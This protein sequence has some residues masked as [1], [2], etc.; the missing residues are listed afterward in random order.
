LK[1]DASSGKPIF[2][3][4]LTAMVTPFNAD[5]SLDKAGVAKLASYLVE[6]GNDGLVLNGTTGESSTVQDDEKTEVV[7][8]V[9]EA[10]GG[11]ACVV[12]GVGSNDTAHSVHLAKE[13]HAAGAD[14]LM[15]VTP[16]YNKPQQAG[17]IAHI[18]EIANATPL[19]VMTYDIPGR[20]GI[21]ITHESFLTLSK[22]PKII[23]N[24]D[25]KADLVAAS[26]A[27]HET[28]LT[29]YS[30]D[31]GLTL[32]MMAVGAVG[33]VS[34]V[35]HLVAPLMQ[36]MVSA[37]ANDD[38]EA[39]RKLNEQLI[40]V[41]RAVMTRMPGAVAVKTVLNEMGLPAGPLRLPL[42]AA[43]EAEKKRLLEELRAA[44]LNC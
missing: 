3:R 9:V 2:G 37:A 38:Y 14:A 33:V 26:E 1:F 16:Y 15:V 27:I 6:Q 35:A 22:N 29:W 41:V 13:A 30:G 17:V 23:A 18:T 11:R 39:A 7:A 31:D 42:V 10:V 43:T 25:A 20:S 36:Q 12:A 24:K 32:P 5:M 40:P 4:V 44:G 21:P 19:P 8:G 34:V 28:G